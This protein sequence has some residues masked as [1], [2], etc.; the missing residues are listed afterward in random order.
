MF[1][2]PPAPFNS[3]L[4]GA[5]ARP[6]IGRAL[7]L[8]SAVA[9]SWGL[10]GCAQPGWL[11]T[12]AP[13][14][15]QSAQVAAADELLLQP[16]WQPF[17]DAVLRQL[18]TQALQTNSTVESARAAVLQARASRQVELASQRPQLTLS[19]GLTRSGSEGSSSVSA[20]AGLDASW[21]LD[22]FGANRSALA[23][24]DAQVVAAQTSLRDVQLTMSAEVALAY[25]QLRSLQAQ[26]DV[27]G[28]NLASQQETLQITQWRAQAGLL[29]SLE[30]EQ[31]LAAT[32]QTSALLPSLSSNLAKARH[33]LATLTGKQPTELDTQLQPVQA[34]PRAPAAIADVIDADRLRQRADVRAAEARVTAALASVDAANAARYPS[35]R[36]G[37]SVGLTALTLAGLSKGA[38]VA[39]TVLAS[40]TAPLF[41]GGAGL[42][43]VEV[44]KATLLQ[45]QASYRGTLLTALKD[46]ED[47]MVSWRNDQQ[48]I[49]SL[50]Q[51]ASAANNAALLANNRYTSGLVDFQT[52]L[53]TQRTLLSAQDSLASVQADQSADYVRLVKAIGGTWQ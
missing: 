53:Q 17:N 2:I 21:E 6:R 34:V 26:L 39:T 25:I 13:E 19:G 36:L 12:A 43:R 7:R 24:Q 42:A 8:G 48:R 29:T 50:Q 15:T 44:Q 23:N 27:A 49:N 1:A 4:P 41:D 11:N 40:M 31:A 3:H 30:V 35:F 22:I 9:L 5:T 38:S 37:G 10:L 45:A 51:A 20:R 33:S 28:R 14:N 52:V 32:A 18:I 16:W 47:T 46:V